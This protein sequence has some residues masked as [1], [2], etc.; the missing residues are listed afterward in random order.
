MLKWISVLLMLGVAQMVFASEV[1][2][3]IAGPVPAVPSTVY[4]GFSQTSI[5]TVTNNV[6]KVLPF[7]LSSASGSVVL[8]R[9]GV[10]NDCGNQ[11]P[12][13]PATCNIGIEIAAPYGQASGAVVD[14]LYMDYQGRAPL[15]GNISFTILP[16]LS[17]TGGSPL[18]L[19]NGQ[20]G[21]L[22]VM[23]VSSSVV[24]HNVT[25]VFTGTALQ[26]NATVTSNS[27]A[28]N[29]A[30]GHSCLIT[31]TAG[32]GNVAA[33]NFN[34][35]G[36]NTEA[37]VASMSV[38]TLTVGEPYEGGIVGCST[39]SGNPITLIA[40]TSDIAPTSNELPWSPTDILLGATSYTNGQSN[41][42]IITAYYGLTAG[43]AAG[44]CATYQVDSAGNTPCVNG[45]TCYDTWYLPS[46]DEL[47]CIGGNYAAIGGFDPTA[48]YYW[49]STE[50]NASAAAAYDFNNP[51]TP[52][53][54]SKTSTTNVRCVSQPA[55]Q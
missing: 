32:N 39:A 50:I 42:N 2:V 23:N 21:A 44:A 54:G 1:P 47:Q 10:A 48:E 24:A 5:F 29:L 25:A 53:V 8:T 3:T 35:E 15:V 4:P 31:I 52:Y 40:A 45:N 37:E 17:I 6:P 22:S 36:T 28:P 49:S 34:V 12:R 13:G 30:P 46:I 41:T 7:S 18:A 14:D 55:A 38:T 19:F 43:Y 26:G 27:C 16:V 51:G 9:L 33:T 11:L 20:A